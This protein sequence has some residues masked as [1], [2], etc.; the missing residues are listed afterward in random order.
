[1]KTKVLVP[2]LLVV[3]IFLFSQSTLAAN[4]TW[5]PAQGTNCD[6]TCGRAGQVAVYSGTEGSK[7][8][9]ATQLYVCGVDVKIYQRQRQQYSSGF[10]PGKNV[11]ATTTCNVPFN[12]KENVIQSFVCLC[13]PR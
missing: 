10:V 9:A 2:S 1:M 8:G 12:G 13:V 11:V 3:G 5:I 7:S 4:Y 6:T